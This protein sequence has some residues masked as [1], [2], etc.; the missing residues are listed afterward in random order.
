MNQLFIKSTIEHT[1]SIES[2]YINNTLDKSLLKQAKSIEGICIKNGLLL[3]RGGEYG[4]VIR[5]V[6][7]LTVTNDEMEEI[8]FIIDKSLHE[9]N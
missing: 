1:I 6:P 5:V 9:L 2:K 4:N 8:L 3:L 7:P